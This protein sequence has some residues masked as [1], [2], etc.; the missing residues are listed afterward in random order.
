MWRIYYDDGSTFSSNDGPPEDAP[1][2]GV[3]CIAQPD[4]EVGRHIVS[5]FDYYWFTYE[6]W[7]GDL[8]G[9]F[10]YLIT[11]GH[12]T[13]KFGRTV[14]NTDFSEIVNR[15]KTDSGLPEK[16]ARRRNER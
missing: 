6:W 12:K 3:I 13:V 10:D 14:S 5:G 1:A 7:G 16:S 15:A 8:F 9:L 11:P 4:P 2:L